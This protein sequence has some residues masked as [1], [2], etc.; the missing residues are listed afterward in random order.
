ML[1]YIHNMQLR[2]MESTMTQVKCILSA[3][4]TG[5]IDFRI[6]CLQNGFLVFLS[7]QQIEFKKKKNPC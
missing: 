5:K 7:F 3:K 6:K 4:A 1:S 2:L